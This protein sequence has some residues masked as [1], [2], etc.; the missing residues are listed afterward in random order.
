MTLVQSLLGEDA[1]W[2]LPRRRMALGGRLDRY[3]GGIFLGAFGVALLLVVGL[4]LIVDLA[5]NLDD[6]LG[7]EGQTGKVL[8]YYLL[9]TPFLYLQV[10]PFVTL[11]AGLFTVLRLQ[12]NREVYAALGAGVSTRRMILPILALGGL[13]AVG[14]VVLREASIGVLGYEHQVLRIELEGKRDPGVFEDLRLKD[15]AGKMIE[16]GAFYPGVEASFGA[17]PGPGASF[18]ALD[19]IRLDDQGR[20]IHYLAGGGTYTG[21]AWQLDEAWV[22]EVTDQDYASRELERLPA[23]LEFDPMDAWIA[24]KGRNEP[25]D[26]SY[27]EALELSRRDPDNVQYQTLL[28]HMLAFP[29]ANVVLLLVGLPFLMQFERGRGSEGLVAGFLLCV[30]YFAADFV[31]LNMGLQG[32]ASP[33][34]SSFL[35]T[36]LFGSLGL[37]LTSSAR[38]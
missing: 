22:E 21:G 10:A 36:L 11:M 15:P 13:S 23:E 29:L 26:L 32:H 30:F 28:L 4:F 2:R 33:A 12:K 7:R 14:M 19:V 16:L 5:G 1:T 35:P 24:W 18:A 31:S 34:L 38:S 3:V 9:H 37:V 27:A 8:R 6:Y 25:L 20:W 17:Q